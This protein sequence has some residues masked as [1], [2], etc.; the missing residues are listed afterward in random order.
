MA[1]EAGLTR[2]AKGEPGRSFSAP[3]EPM[4]YAEMSL[5]SMFTT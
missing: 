1:T 5:L 4:L 2:A 3:L